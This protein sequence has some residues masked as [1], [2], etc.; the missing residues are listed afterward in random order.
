L[1]AYSFFLQNYMISDLTRDLGMGIKRERPITPAA[2]NPQM[3]DTNP[4]EV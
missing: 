2:K 3:R 4:A 1:E